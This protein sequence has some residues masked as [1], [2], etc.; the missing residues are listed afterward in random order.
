M[1]IVAYVREPEAVRRVLVHLDLPTDAP[2][3]APAR[4]PPQEVLFEA[5]A[6]DPTDT[7]TPFGPD[8]DQPA[9]DPDPDDDLPVFDVVYR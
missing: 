5:E 8:H 9:I 2:R 6:R 3:P 4:A 7:A 1:R